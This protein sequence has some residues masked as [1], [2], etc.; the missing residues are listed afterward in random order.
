MYYEIM[1]SPP[2]KQIKREFIIKH[3]DNILKIVNQ[4]LEKDAPIAFNNYDIYKEPF[5]TFAQ[6]IIEKHTLL[7]EPKIEYIIQ[8][9]VLIDKHLMIQ[10]KA[11]AR[12]IVEIMKKYNDNV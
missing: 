12:T 4:M 3:K 8:D 9:A 11:K 7:N 10:P 1:S 6:D 2:K 5:I